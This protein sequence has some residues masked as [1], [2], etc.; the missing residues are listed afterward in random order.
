MFS[1][2]E[3]A[4]EKSVIGGFTKNVSNCACCCDFE[5]VAIMTTIP[6]NSRKNP[7]R[8]TR[9]GEAVSVSFPLQRKGYRH[10]RAD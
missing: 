9:R 8:T 6:A 2:G 7:I 1:I 4:P 10:R 5:I 3:V